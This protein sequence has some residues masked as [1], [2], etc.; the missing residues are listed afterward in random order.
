MDTILNGMV[1]YGKVE[2][3][4]EMIG[5]FIIGL[6]LLV[7]GFFFF[8][9]DFK[10]IKGSIINKQLVK[11]NEFV[12]TVVYKVNNVDYKNNITVNSGSI[13]TNDTI[14]IYYNPRNPND[15]RYQSFS[16]YLIGLFFIFCSLLI[17]SFG[18]INYYLA[19]NYKEYALFEA[20]T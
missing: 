7:I 19:K 15:I 18:Y 6:I 14:N 12:V 17:S 11:Q 1:M 3:T 16:N 5:S 20:L 8:F 4:I 9:S 10:K 13:P 2:A